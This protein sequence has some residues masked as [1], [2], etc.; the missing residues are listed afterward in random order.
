[1]FGS[2]ASTAETRSGKEY[3][4]RIVR[5]LEAAGI[6]AE[7]AIEHGRSPRAA[8]VAYAHEIGPDLVVMGAHGHRGVKD[9]IFGNTINAVRHQVSVPVLVVGDEPPAR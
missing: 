9:L 3:F 4:E 1:V 6:S 2:L 5:E 8:I 7:F